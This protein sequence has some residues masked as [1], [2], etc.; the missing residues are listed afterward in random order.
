MTGIDAQQLFGS[1]PPPWP[2]PLLP[3]IQRRLAASGQRFVILDDDPTG[4]QTL[5]GLP[6]LA[7]WDA[8]TLSAEVERSAAFFVLTNSRALRE[9]EAVAVAHGVGSALRSVAQTTGRSLVAGY[10]GDSTLRG[11]YP[12]ETDALYAAMTGDAAPP[13]LI[14]APYFAEGG[15]F[16]INDT[17]YVQQGDRLVPAA[18]TEFARD[19]R[20]AYVHSHLPDWLEARTGGRVHAAD[21]VSVSIEDLRLGGPE[22]VTAKLRGVPAGGIAL[23]N[24]ACDR[25]VEVFVLG[26]L[27]AEAA[28]QSFL[29]RTAASFVRVRAG[30]EPRPLLSAQELHP[31]GEG[32]LIVVGSYVDRTTAQLTTLLAQPGTFGVE[33]HVPALLAD[34]EA[35]IAR[36]ATEVSRAM[37]RDIPPSPRKP[38]LSPVEGERGPG[39][40]VVLY[41]SRGLVRSAPGFDA[42][43]VGDRITEALCA[44]LTRLERRPGFLIVKGGST[45]H[46]IATRGLGMKRAVVLGQLLAGVPV[47]QLGPESKYPDLPIVVF[48]GNVGGPESLA[49]AVRALRG[50]TDA[51]PR[52]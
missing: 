34:P 35:E 42:V 40:E 14:F 41:T 17:Q 11:H 31:Y 38:V 18:Q 4:G 44:I 23:M 10:R 24:A 37:A 3:E 16:T 9:P 47:W 27:D 12:A 28:G 43:A 48:P 1:L 20:F 5:H 29:Y 7:A 36:V 8:E 50:D 51:R 49:D 19:P 25:D 6:V 45:A 33:L 2:Q 21:V 32:G 13:T 52:E 26:L 22:A 30:V 39:G 15:R 46:G